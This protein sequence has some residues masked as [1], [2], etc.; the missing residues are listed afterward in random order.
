MSKLTVKGVLPAGIEVG[1]VVHRDF[2]LRPQLVRDSIEGLQDARA[3]DNPSY[4]G[5][6]MLASQIISLGSLPKESIN[7]EL[8]MD[9]YELDMQELMG[10]AAQLRERLKT[11]REERAQ[12]AQTATGAA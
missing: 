4:L 7:A 6:V 9:A 3:N 11:F 8:L 10:G 5:L 2:E 1:G 12:P